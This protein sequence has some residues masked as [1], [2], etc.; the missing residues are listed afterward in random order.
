MGVWEWTIVIGVLLVV[1][2]LFWLAVNWR[3][4]RYEDASERSFTVDDD[5]SLYNDELP[6]GGARTVG[7]RDVDDI[8]RTNAVIRDKA[9]ANK[10]RLTGIRH[11]S[12][13]PRVQTTLFDDQQGGLDDGA[14]ESENTNLNH[15]PLLLDP[16]DEHSKIISPADLLDKTGAD[17][18]AQGNAITALDDEQHSDE[19]IANDLSDTASLSATSELEEQA[20]EPPNDKTDVEKTKKRRTKR[21]Q[22]KGKANRSDAQDTTENSADKQPPSEV[23]IINLMTSAETP[24]LGIPLLNA[25]KALGMQY[26]EMD[27]FHYRGQRGTAESKFSMANLL[28][29]GTFDIEDFASLQ[30]HALCFFFELEA[31][32]DNLAIYE[33]M[34][35][36]I[37]SLKEELGGAMRDDGRSVFTNQTSEHYRNRIRDFQRRRLLNPS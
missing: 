16:S 14:G 31:G 19:A 4:R 18:K 15:V 5:M 32:K 20:E 25:L 10:S 35:S 36:V 27:I 22:K 33:A 29:P 9:E 12:S 7:Y 1:A 34:L 8:E 17:E 26:G 23:M 28:A 6:S 2:L 3:K 11:S 30:T 24:Y 37:H 13:T 21:K